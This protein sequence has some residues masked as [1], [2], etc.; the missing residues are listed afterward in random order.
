METKDVMQALALSTVIVIVCIFV[1]DMPV[2]VAQVE[3]SVDLTQ[4]LVTQVAQDQETL[5][6]I[7]QKELLIKKERKEQER[8]SKS[9]VALKPWEK[10]ST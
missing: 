7:K 8:R 9:V 3:Q 10:R 2:G 1:F 5:A 6:L 4:L